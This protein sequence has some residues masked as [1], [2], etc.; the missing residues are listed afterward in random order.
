MNTWNT[1]LSTLE[2]HVKIAQVND[3]VHKQQCFY[4]FDTPFSPLGLFV[5]LF[6]FNCFGYRFVKLY[7]KKTGSRLYLHIKRNNLDHSNIPTEESIS[8]PLKPTKL[9][10]GVDGGFPLQQN[11]LSPVEKFHLVILPEFTF[12]PITTELPSL[13]YDSLMS[14]IGRFNFYFHF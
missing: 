4:S 13:I 8:Q 10:I 2:N 5:C 14:I 12:I 6:S 3:T 11:T 1:T 9:G 7:F